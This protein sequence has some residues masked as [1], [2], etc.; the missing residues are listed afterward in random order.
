MADFIRQVLSVRDQWEKKNSSDDRDA[1]PL[2]VWFRG[3]ENA[4]WRLLPRLY[5]LKKFDENEIRSE[6]KLRAFQLMSESH[7][8]KDDLEWYF[9]MQHYGAPTRL[10]DWTDGA[11][12]A[13]Y[14]SVKAARPYK[15]ASVWM[16]DPVWLNEESL[17]KMDQNN[18]ISGVLLPHWKESL[19]WLPEPFEESLTVT[20]PV[21]IDPPHVARRVSV[22]RSRFTVHGTSKRGLDALVTNNPESRLVKFL[23]SNKAAKE[24]L[25]DLSTCGI[26]ETSVF[27]DL[28]GLS[29]E[30]Q[31]KWTQ[32]RKQK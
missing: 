32:I 6:F 27:P 31:T 13:L 5:R 22:Q 3:Q 8:P 15:N 18:Y 17:K 23:I 10:I 7:I 1:D 11:L 29:R 26:V 24:I 4:R 19:R 9:L 25:E 30:L 12:I 16:L 14:F 20:L 21:A 2:Q 28:E